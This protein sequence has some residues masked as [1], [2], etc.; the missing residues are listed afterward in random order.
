MMNNDL[1]LNL[2]GD[3]KPA[4]A[5]HRVKMAGAL[6]VKDPAAHQCIIQGMVGVVLHPE[7]IDQI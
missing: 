6:F 3:Q 4:K 2:V 1:R 7:V 5:E